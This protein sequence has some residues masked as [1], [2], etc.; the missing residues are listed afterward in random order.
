[1]R[2]LYP[3]APY[4]SSVRVEG[5]FGEVDIDISRDPNADPRLLIL[6]GPNGSGKTTL[7][8]LITS[9]ISPAENAGHRTRLSKIPFLRAVVTVDGGVSIE[10]KK[11]DGL[12]GDYDWIVKKPGASPL[13]M[14]MKV[15]RGQILASH[16]NQDQN[17][18][19]DEMIREL[20]A[21]V[22]TA[23]LLNDK[24]TF[25]SPEPDGEIFERIGPDGKVSFVSQRVEGAEDENDPVYR[26]LV[27]IVSS[28]RREALLLSNRGNQGAQAIYSSLLNRVIATP[29]GVATGSNSLQSL[30]AQLS[31]LQTRSEILSCYGLVASVDHAS[32]LRS[33][34]E[35]SGDKESIV[36]NILSPYVES[37]TARL[38]AIQSLHDSIHGWVES[39]S[40]FFYPKKIRFKVGEQIQIESR[41]GRPLTAKSLSSGERHLLLM[42]TKAFQLRS[43]G[44]ILLIDEPELSLNS[45]WQRELMHA[46]LESFSSV[47]C[48]LVVA[49]HSLEIAARYQS[50]VMRFA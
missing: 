1:M 29:H 36:V 5:L 10:A 20:E 46:L 27:E 48:Q 32:L 31:T 25:Y 23:E 7:L 44:G 43:T 30:G 18:R 45:S 37:L 11:R 17:R 6:Y 3:P 24:R 41:I 14:L 4:I 21:V 12:T 50:S 35:V 42:L 47:G 2:N 33:L 19:H 49:T 38:D 22:K 39:I 26:G 40:G 15:I 16:W 9:L 34:S 28:V 13:A 8:E